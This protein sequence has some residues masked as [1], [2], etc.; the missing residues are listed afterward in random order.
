MAAHSDLGFGRGQGRGRETRKEKKEREG[1]VSEEVRANK[2]GGTHTHGHTQSHVHTLKRTHKSLEASHLQLTDHNLQLTFLLSTGECVSRLDE[3][4]SVHTHCCILSRG[5]E[6]ACVC[7]VLQA[8]S[9][10]PAFVQWKFFFYS[11][12]LSLSLTQV[13]Y[14]DVQSIFESY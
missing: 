14:T 2:D 11:L 12:C 1:M 6:C 9:R 4:V 13:Y 7:T 10:A 3:C 8:G 5:V